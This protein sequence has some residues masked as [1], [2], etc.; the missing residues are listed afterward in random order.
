MATNPAS[1]DTWFERSTRGSGAELE[2][3]GDSISVPHRRGQE[4]RLAELAFADRRIVLGEPVSKAFQSQRELVDVQE[5]S[6]PVRLFVGES[7]S[8]RSSERVQ[9]PLELV[10]VHPQSLTDT[11]TA[12][13][14][15]WDRG[16]SPC[17]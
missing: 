14:R 3:T 16:R 1:R 7:I 12:E 8:H 11:S 5:L 10:S 4:R 13:E 6:E 9:A 17:R 2:R 15:N